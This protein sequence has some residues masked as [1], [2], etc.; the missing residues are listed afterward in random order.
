[1]NDVIAKNIPAKEIF[2]KKK[3]AGYFLIKIIIAAGLLLFIVEK[4]NLKEIFSVFSTADYNLIIFAF[5]LSFLNLYIQFLKWETVCSNYL[6]INN[7]KKIFISLFHGFAAGIFTPARIGEYFSR[8]LVL[9]E[10]S[11]FKI[12]AA[13]FVDKFFPLLPVAFF[14][15]VSFIFYL[16]YHYQLSFFISFLLLISVIIITYFFLRQIFKGK[17]LKI[18]P[19]KIKYSK[20][21]EKVLPSIEQLTKLDSKFISRMSFISVSFY[22]CYLVQFAILVSAFSHNFKFLQYLWNGSLIMFSKSII[23]QISIGELGIREGFSVYFFSKIGE[24]A[25]TAFNAAFFLFLINLVFPSLL[26]L[27]LLY[28]K[29]DD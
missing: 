29:S 2:L 5:I 28:K 14:G 7:K 19:D 4:I 23:P 3:Q 1:M 24:T 21:F 26:G 18:I 10:K 8:G 22:F 17:F 25:A 16:N 11:V 15:G 27:I 20:K 6:N 12:A 9:R 13:T